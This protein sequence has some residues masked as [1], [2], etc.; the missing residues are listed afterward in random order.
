MVKF[1]RNDHIWY[2]WQIDKLVEMLVNKEVRVDTRD[3]N[4][5]LHSASSYFRYI[6]HAK[7]SSSIF[8]YFVDKFWE[9]Y[10]PDLVDIIDENSMDG[11]MRELYDPRDADYAILI[12]LGFHPVRLVPLRNLLK[13]QIGYLR[14]VTERRKA[15]PPL[16][17]PASIKID[18]IENKQSITVGRPA[19][20][21]DTCI[22]EYERGIEV[23]Q[24]RDNL[25]DYI[26]REDLDIAIRDYKE[27]E[28]NRLLSSEFIADDERGR[29]NEGGIL[30]APSETHP[31]V[32]EACLIGGGRRRRANRTTSRS[33]SKS[34]SKSRRPRGKSAPRSKRVGNRRG[35]KNP[36]RNRFGPPVTKSR[37]CYISDLVQVAASAYT[38]KTFQMC[39]NDMDPALLSTIMIGQ[40]R[41]TEYYFE[42]LNTFFRVIA[43]CTNISGDPVN[44]YINIGTQD[45]TTLIG[46]W[47]DARDGAENPNST[48]VVTWDNNTDTRKIVQGFNPA[49]L[50]RKGV[51]YNS[52]IYAGLY[53]A[54]PVSPIFVNLV[55][56][57]DNSGSNVKVDTNISFEMFTSWYIQRAQRDGGP[58]LEAEVSDRLNKYNSVPLTNEQ[59]A[60]VERNSRAWVYSDAAPPRREYDHLAGK[61]ISRT[62]IN[63]Q[64]VSQVL[65]R[66]NSVDRFKQTVM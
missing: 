24:E 65:K 1:G 28:L 19:I 31:Y 20:L 36:D 21:K 29:S 39:I 61:V 7:V 30:I 4:G 38:V 22:E 35:M 55:W 17:N 15:L 44:F 43:A 40:E 8:K 33:R 13:D 18:T 52:E 25:M 64:P 27:M 23:E 66:V 32:T 37:L 46:S 6:F 42:Y 3:K 59:K 53:N 54:N 63:T 60:R 50:M 62:V 9:E 2:I 11:V 14:Q 26:R 34:R 51:Y 12:E 5:N 48:K 16:R 10:H 49:D 57:C 58:F 41:F 45:W 56:Y 47:Q